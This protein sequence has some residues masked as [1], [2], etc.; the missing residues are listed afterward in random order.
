MFQTPPPVSSLPKRECHNSSIQAFRTF[1]GR[2]RHFFLCGHG[3]MPKIVYHADLHDRSSYASRT[4]QLFADTAHGTTSLLLEGVEMGTRL[5][6]EHCFNDY[7]PS[8]AECVRP[9]IFGLEAAGYF[10]RSSR[11]RLLNATLSHLEQH[12]TNIRAAA[13]ELTA[14]DMGSSGGSA[15]VLS[16]IQYHLSGKAASA[17][18]L[19]DM[20]EV[21]Q[22]LPRLAECTCPVELLH[23]LKRRIPGKANVGKMLDDA[24]FAWE[25]MESEVAEMNRVLFTERESHMATNIEIVRKRFPDRD[26]HVLIGIAHLCPAA[27]SHASTLLTTNQY[28]LF[29]AHQ[30]RLQEPRLTTLQPGVIA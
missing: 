20:P 3:Y 26:I 29:S 24:G 25:D 1:C 8:D 2:S 10:A 19:V 11:A 23:C 6:S 7:H 30:R 21:V 18:A 5:T 27:L 28:Q 14:K 16:Y 9:C 15:A 17:S 22:A 13:Q 4:R 12:N